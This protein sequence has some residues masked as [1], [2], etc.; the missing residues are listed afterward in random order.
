[1]TGPVRRQRLYR[2]S[3]ADTAKEVNRQ[4]DDAIDAGLLRPSRSES[5]SP[6]HFAHKAY[7]S[8]RLCIDQRGLNEATRKDAYSLPHAKDTLDELKDAKSHPHLDLAFGFWKVRVQEEDVRTLR[9]KQI[10]V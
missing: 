6:I 3:H 2:L 7:G 5:G 10:M 1:M 8:L 9:S 4:V